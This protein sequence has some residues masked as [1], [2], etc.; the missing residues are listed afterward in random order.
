MFMR[1]KAN[2]FLLLP[3]YCVCVLDHHFAP[4]LANFDAGIAFIYML[5]H[6][7]VYWRGITCIRVHVL[8][9]SAFCVDMPGHHNLK[10]YSA[11]E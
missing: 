2:C 11:P 8:L 9:V 6:T 5:V 7:S 4:Y 10:Y 1:R 3:C